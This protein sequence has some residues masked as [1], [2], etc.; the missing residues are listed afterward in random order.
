MLCLCSREMPSETESQT[1]NCCDRSSSSAGPG[2]WRASAA[3]AHA[4]ASPCGK[5]SP[6]QRG[7]VACPACG[8]PTIWTSKHRAPTAAW[9]LA[10][11][12]WAAQDASAPHGTAPA[13]R[14]SG[15]R[16]PAPGPGRDASSAEPAAPRGATSAAGGPDAGHGLQRAAAAPAAPA[17]PALGPGQRPPAWRGRSSA[18]GAPIQQRSLRPELRPP[19]DASTAGRARAALWSTRCAEVWPSPD[20]RRPCEAAGGHQ[21]DLAV[22]KPH[23]PRAN[24]EACLRQREQGADRVHHLAPVGA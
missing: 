7:L 20:A 5:H 19:A 2:L 15:G 8:V 1:Q 23:Q 11:T 12:T 9:E 6:S 16:L 24:P 17:P 14:G 4:T 10:R 21:R 13:A 18:H 3:D 22:L